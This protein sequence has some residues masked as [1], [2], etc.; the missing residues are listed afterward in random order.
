MLVLKLACCML[1]AAALG[2]Q[3]PPAD[4][5]PK[6][7]NTGAPIRLPFTCSDEDMRT[8]GLAC[9]NRQACPVYLELTGLDS[10]GSRLLLSG[11]LHT[12]N[13]T[14]FSVL[15]SSDDDGR[16]WLEPHDRIRGAGLDQVQFFDLES[17]WVSGQQLG[18]LPRDPFLLLTRDGGKTWR[19]RPL[20][21]ESRVGSIEYFHFDSKT[22]GT[23][24]IDRTQA[25]EEGDRYAVLESMT[26]GENWTVRETSDRPIPRKKAAAAATVYRLRTDAATKSYRLEKH[27]GEQWQPVARFLVRVGECRDAE[28]VIPPEPPQPAE[29]QPATPNEP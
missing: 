14:L 26:G 18:A 12:E 11:N 20:F 17:G 16:T 25:G 1:M 3:A 7:S 5:P 8:A 13:A 6:L 2:A 28:V 21:N 10:S 22:H 4:Q 24:W 23:A 15:L 9:P 29:P 19:A 27:T